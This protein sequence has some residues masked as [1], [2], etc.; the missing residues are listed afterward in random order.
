MKSLFLSGVLLLL[1]AITAHA[2][3]DPHS[4][5]EP[6]KVTMTA[7]DLDLDV[8]FDSKELKGSADL[9]LA[10]HDPKARTLVLDTRDL[11]IES[12]KT[13]DAQGKESDASF[14]LDKRDPIFGSALRITL[15]EQVP[16]VRIRYRTSPK[17]SGLQW[18]SPEQTAS[19]KQPFMFSQSQAI[20]ARSWIPLQDTPSVRFTYTAH[21]KAPKS[22]RVLMSANNDVKHPLN[23]EYRFVM[24][25]AI[26][27]YLLAIAVGELDA[28]VTG[29]RTAVFAEPSVVV[30]AA[31]EL[32]DTEK[33]IEATEKLYGPYRWERYDILI[34]PASFPFGGMENPRLTFATPTILAG[35]KSLVGL[36]AHELAHSWSGNLVTNASAEHMWMNEGFTTY[37]ENRIVEELY[38]KEVA[39]MHLVV[40]DQEL[41]VEMQD[42]KPDQQLLVTNL[43]GI[44]P[45]EGLSGVPYDKGRWFLRFLESRY[46]R[47]VF[48]PFLRSY[49][50]HFAFQSITSTEFLQFYSENLEKKHLGKVSAAEIDAWLH[51]PGIP[52]DA[53]VA[54][55]ARFDAVDKAASDFIA[56]NLAAKD[57]QAK[58]WVTLEWVRFIN[59]LPNTP[60]VEQIRSL[61]DAW[62]LS[63]SGNAEIAFRWYVATVRAGYTDARPQIAAFIERIGRRKLVV[64]IYEELAKTPDGK[65]FAIEVYAK[66]KP[67]YH[68][69]TQGSVEKVLGL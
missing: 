23:G 1:S 18:M 12:V 10:W 30:A 52:A 25:Q 7:L 15:K 31:K 13:V 3:V 26:P 33:M 60:E 48:D 55:S 22:L 39:T 24:K 17:A 40:D 27:P 65:A 4:Y 62:S 64:P 61:D 45:D 19:K 54:H 67:G 36:I 50:D 6:S 49:F 63:N 37:V 16:N 66:A 35:D 32:E 42:M 53:P 56:G 69:L 9:S 51:L 38:G 11:D 2:E 59:A 46:G 43:D 5:A 47:D 20:H 68:P 34:L 8:D 44:D 58:D 29:P 57:I 28:R 21:I 41:L 14:S